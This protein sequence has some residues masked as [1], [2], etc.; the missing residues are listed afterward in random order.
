MSA[1]NRESKSNMQ[2]LVREGYQK[3]DYEGFFR[4]AKQL[5]PFETD[6]FEQ[7]CGLLTTG[8]KILDLGCGPGIPYDLYLSHRGYRL[9][10]I[11]FCRKHVRQ[12]AERVPLGRF[13]CCDI[14]EI[15][16]PQKSFDAIVSLYTIFHL[17]RTR[18]RDMIET[19]YRTL[20][21]GGV[22]LLTFGT[23][24][25]EYGEEDDWLGE[26]MAWSSFPPEVYE[27]ILKDCEFT[28]LRSQF[29][30]RPEDEEY[31]WWVL[32]QK[33]RSRV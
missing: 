8:G 27:R 6:F 11:D 4:L 19:I 5:T 9:T 24:D 3:I 15:Q 22:A 12:A 30:G 17:P 14:S 7:M 20:G 13:I 33:D 29:E 32:A 28:I 16:L 1:V 2:A 18:H 10:G 26:R 25:S 31:H 21:S 23:S